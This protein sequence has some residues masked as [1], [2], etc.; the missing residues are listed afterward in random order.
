MAGAAVVAVELE[1]D[2]AGKVYRC[3][4]R[5]EKWAG[6]V[7]LRMAAESEVRQT[8]LEISHGKELMDQLQLQHVEPATRSTHP[9]FLPIV[10]PSAR[11]AWGFARS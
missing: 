2:V 7:M 11:T 1:A 5:V 10:Q 3:L 8:G 4:G 9:C 6:H